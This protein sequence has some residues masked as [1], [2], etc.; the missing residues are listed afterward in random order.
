M[1]APLDDVI[2]NH[3]LLEYFKITFENRQ[4]IKV[5]LDRVIDLEI[6]LPTLLNT[7]VAIKSHCERFEKDG[8]LTYGERPG[9]NQVLD[10]LDQHIHDA[11]KLVSDAKCLDKR[12]NSTS[13]LV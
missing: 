10:E 11:R 13:L 3:S 7:I 8:C 9:F 12:A 2:D 1:L 5:L 6:I 4:A